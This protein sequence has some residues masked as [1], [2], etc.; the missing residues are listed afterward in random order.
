MNKGLIVH[1]VV[2]ND[3]HQVLIIKRTSTEDVFPGYWD[4]PGGTL[5]DSEDPSIGAI[6]EVKEETDLDIQEP[7]LFFQR[8]NIDSG[9]NKQFITLIFLVKYS[10]GNVVLNPDDHDE[11]KW[12]SIS[13]I[14]KYKTVDYLADCLNLLASKEHTLLGL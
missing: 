3:K 11:Y 9:K 14:T 4:I 5:E 13:D 8:S 1:T 10:G 6:R 2:F 12:I 7:S